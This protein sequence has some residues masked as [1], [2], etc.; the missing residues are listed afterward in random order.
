MYKQGDCFRHLASGEICTILF[1][2]HWPGKNI[3]K[4]EC[5]WLS[6]NYMVTA[7][8]RQFTCDP[9]NLEEFFVLAP[10]ATVLYGQV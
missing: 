6:E 5:Q 8:N 3:L 7:I 10:A 9:Q 4:Y 1:I 2:C